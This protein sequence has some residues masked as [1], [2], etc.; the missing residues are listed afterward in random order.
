MSRL[1]V[2]R[3][4]EEIMTSKLG[5]L[6]GISMV[7]TACRFDPVANLTGDGGLPD[8]VTGDRQLQDVVG[9]DRRQGDC[10]PQDIQSRCADDGLTVQTC[11]ADGT[12]SSAAPCD[13]ACMSG[14]SSDTG[15]PIG[16]CAHTI[17]FSNSVQYSLLDNVSDE[18]TG[19]GCDGNHP[20]VIDTSSLTV[21]LDGRSLLTEEVGEPLQQGGGHGIELMVLPLLRFQV[22]SGCMVRIQGNRALAIVTRDGIE[23]SG[24]IDAS[25][26]AL[27]SGPGALPAG[28]ACDGRD[29]SNGGANGLGGG[30]GGGR[31]G[32]GG[33]G[34]GVA[35]VAG[36]GGDSVRNPTLVPLMGGCQGGSG[37]ESV[38]A[39]T[40]GGKGGGALM[41]ASAGSITITG[42][43]RVS[44]GIGASS[45]TAAGGGGGSG[46]SLLIEAPHVIV[47]GRLEAEGGPGGAGAGAAG[48][49]GGKDD[50]PDGEGG[51]T[52]SGTGG[53]GG[54]GAGQIRINTPAGMQPVVTGVLSPAINHGSQI[55]PGGL[56]VE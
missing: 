41:L 19:D 14:V 27:L 1:T 12:W 40:L 4:G 53:G 51:A 18:V 6:L 8:V 50:H 29:G 23:V 3:V 13:I 30:G 5:L 49:A 46:G 36:T 11:E 35:S 39:S 2:W 17:L 43:V 44:G 16:Y 24:T 52:V 9:M 31:F 34:G 33:N 37:A 54:G 21:T 42:T 47:A 7:L 26:D 20:I 15:L 45:D 22:P 56:D 10:D 48:G 28:L 25:A 55:V 32:K 38:V